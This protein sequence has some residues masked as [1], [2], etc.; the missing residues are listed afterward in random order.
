MTYDD[1][2]LE[3]ASMTIKQTADILKVSQRTVVRMLD[4]GRLKGNLV[5]T[6]RGKVWIIH[7]VSIAE[8]IILKRAM[9]TKNYPRA[10]RKGK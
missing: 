10:K 7:P 8:Q 3:K 5:N 4:D 9:G 1:D 6:L 2:R